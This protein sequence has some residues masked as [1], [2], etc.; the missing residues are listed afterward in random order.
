MIANQI[1]LFVVTVLANGTSGGPFVYVSAYA[2][3]QLPHGL[4]AVSL[5]DDVRARARARAD[6]RRDLTALR[7]QLS[8]GCDSPRSSSRPPPRS[9]SVSR[10]RSS[11]RSSNAVRSPPTTPSRSPT[12]SPPSRSGLLPFSLYL[13]ALRAFT[14][15]LDT[16]TPFLINCV[17][18]VVNI[19]LAFP[20]YA[21][22][23]IPGLALAFSLA[24]VVGVGRRPLRVAPRPPRDRRAAAGVHRR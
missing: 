2:F 10:V 21:W 13:F 8:R 9:T 22:L 17:E 24:Y 19:V 5:V 15:R 16:R 11:S 18:N 20:L 6:A 12:R 14:S 23:G 7:A 4:L 1:A 3:F